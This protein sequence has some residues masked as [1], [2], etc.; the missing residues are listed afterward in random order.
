MLSGWHPWTLAASGDPSNMAASSASTLK[1]SLRSTSATTVVNHLFWSCS[2]GA[3]E[4]STQ[5]WYI[6]RDTGKWPS[7]HHFFWYYWICYRKG[8]FHLAGPW[9]TLE[10]DTDFQ[11]PWLHHCGSKSWHVSVLPAHFKSVVSPIRWSTWLKSFDTR[12]ISQQTLLQAVT[13]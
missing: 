11:R 8:N 5:C 1:Q 10:S 3:P 4:Y 7:R 13:G 6:R 12:P 9:T 2:F